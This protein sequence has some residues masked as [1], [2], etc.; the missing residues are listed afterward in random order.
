MKNKF[1]NTPTKPT[2][3]RGGK[4]GLGGFDITDT[5]GELG[6]T[7]A[8]MNSLFSQD[9]TSADED[10]NSYTYSSDSEDED[11]PI[12]KVMKS[13]V[14]NIADE[15]FG[16][17]ADGELS[18]DE[19]KLL[20]DIRLY[21]A[22]ANDV[23]A[24]NEESEGSEYIADETVDLGEP[25]STASTDKKFIPWDKDTELPKKPTTRYDKNSTRLIENH[26]FARKKTLNVF[27]KYKDKVGDIVNL[28]KRLVVEELNYWNSINLTKVSPQEI[29]DAEKY[30]LTKYMNLVGDIGNRGHGVSKKTHA[31]CLFFA[32]N[33]SITVMN[34]GIGN[35]MDDRNCCIMWLK[36]H[37][38]RSILCQGGTRGED[39][40]HLGTELAE[41]IANELFTFLD[42]MSICCKGTASNEKGNEWGTLKPQ[43]EAVCKSFGDLD[44]VHYQEV[45]N[46]FALANEARHVS[47]H[48]AHHRG[49]SP[50]ILLITSSHTLDLMNESKFKKNVG[51]AVPQSNEWVKK[52][53]VCHPSAMMAH[54]TNCFIHNLERLTRYTEHVHMSIEDFHDMKLEIDGKDVMIKVPSV[55]DLTYF[56]VLGNIPGY[57]DC[58]EADYKARMEC[59]K[60]I[61]VA[62][63]DHRNRLYLAARLS[64]AGW[65]PDNVTDAKAHVILEKE[66]ERLGVGYN[67]NTFFD[68]LQE[69]LKRATAGLTKWA[70][71]QLAAMGIKDVRDKD[72]L[73]FCMSEK[74]KLGE[75]PLQPWAVNLCKKYNLGD[76]VDPQ[77]AMSV[78]WENG[79]HPVQ[80]WY[81]SECER[82]KYF[83]LNVD[84]NL[85]SAKDAKD[86]YT[87]HDSFKY[88]LKFIR[89]LAADGTTN[90]HNGVF[91][92]G[93]TKEN[94][95][96]KTTR[97]Y[98]EGTLFTL[99]LRRP[100]D[101]RIN[102]EFIKKLKLHQWHSVGNELSNA[103]VQSRVKG[104][105]EAEKK[106]TKATVVTEV[107]SSGGK[108]LN[109]KERIELKKKQKK[110]QQKKR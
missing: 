21:S 62:F 57:S 95:E 102:H 54:L 27:L 1:K 33:K 8:G 44:G 64:R 10:D 94:K 16:F 22:V 26:L 61:M 6:G 79:K 30:F 15:G 38:L 88:H 98:I 72:A 77:D 43:L 31:M 93:E 3:P 66:K 78:L 20:N 50:Y 12:L 11:D 56:Y 97:D 105:E 109:P 46:L 85:P 69:K 89:E 100:N 63:E 106:D 14:A 39:P 2:N 92:F 13:N 28:L 73:S 82:L 51:G 91:Y 4:R 107:P 29:E 96:Y 47:Y 55:D 108:K 74:W 34:D 110:Q 81:L 9:S 7:T 23:R 59:L 58:T 17:N 42:S 24:V 104:V 71:D 76:N 80:L 90:W 86:V 103:R 48:A 18:A 65:E 37:M 70:K 84:G 52:L 101:W 68:L 40:S 67:Q 32:I 75:N 25:G 53:Y 35:K 60:K 99:A 5:D 87:Q 45:W 19:V 49:K 41:K 36:R 83:N